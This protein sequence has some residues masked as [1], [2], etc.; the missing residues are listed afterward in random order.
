MI[1]N[2]AGTR[3]TRF[4]DGKSDYLSQSSMPIYFGL[5]DAMRADA[6][7]VRWPSG[8]KQVISKDLPVNGLL[9]I[10]EGRD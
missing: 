8:I 9:R 10:V 5:G 4:H 3:Q 7:E 1:V 6:V 2:A